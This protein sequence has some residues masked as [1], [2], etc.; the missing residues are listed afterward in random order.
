MGLR[1][2]LMGVQEE[3]ALARTTAKS[4]MNVL[5][6]S[7][8][9]LQESLASREHA[10]RDGERA[11]AEQRAVVASLEREG[12]GLRKQLAQ[13]QARTR[14]W[15]ATATQHLRKGKEFERMRQ[16]LAHQLRDMQQQAEPREQQIAE[17]QEQIR[18][19]D[20]EHERSVRATTNLDYIVADKT[21]KMS[22]LAAEA[23]RL[24][25]ALSGRQ[26]HITQFCEDLEAVVQRVQEKDWKQALLQLHDTYV[27]RGPEGR[28]RPRVDPGSVDEL[29]RQK[30]GMAKAL[31]AMQRSKS[32]AEAKSRTMDR[33]RVQEASELLEDLNALRR[34]NHGLRQEVQRLKSTRG[35][36]HSA[37]DHWDA[38]IAA[39]VEVVGAGRA[40]MRSASSSSSS[41][42]GAQPSTASSVSVGFDSRGGGGGGGRGGGGWPNN[43]RP[44]KSGNSSSN[45]PQSSKIFRGLPMTQSIT[46]LNLGNNVSQ[47]AI[48][49][50]RIDELERTVSLGLLSTSHGVS[51][52]Y[53][54][55][56]VRAAKARNL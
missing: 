25:K 30:G 37:A 14:E 41:R 50:G 42:V 2:K 47:T 53:F 52:L 6:K 19:L 7:A 1:A 28:G 4:E 17:L 11:A 32:L 9:A 35:A 44:R 33:Q 46:Q 51:D 20:N 54:C 38:Q 49:E 21:S 12:A 23:R 8:A 15:K 22:N 45:R 10:L 27:V 55:L 13:E 3:V 39:Q 31:S 18:E 56:A 43:G 36:S 40:A 26:A 48:L 5:R 34:E 29:L 16:V 24:R